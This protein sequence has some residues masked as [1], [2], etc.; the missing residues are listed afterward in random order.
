M[1]SNRVKSR[2]SAFLSEEQRTEFS[3]LLL[4]DLMAVLKEAGILHSSLVVSSDRTILDYA[5]KQGATA[6]PEEEDAGVNAAVVRGLTAVGGGVTV[7]V[8]P[9]DLPLLRPSELRRLL[10]LKTA[11]LDVVLAPSLGFNGTNALLFVSGSDFPLS[12]D[13]DS[14]WNHLG[15]CGRL[16]LRAGVSCESGLMFD[17]DAPDDLR[18]LSKSRSMRKSAVFARRALR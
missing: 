14:F 10:R 3:R 4:G 15:S 13:D 5:V 17:V 9:S 18:L 2:L 1:K 11:G 12:Y 6:V 16:G 8:L 7:L